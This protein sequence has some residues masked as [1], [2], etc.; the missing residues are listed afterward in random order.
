MYCLA[1]LALVLVALI[2]PLLCAAA[3]TPAY[4]H[5]HATLPAAVDLA[6]DWRRVAIRVNALEVDTMLFAY[7]GVKLPPGLT[8]MD[9]SW[10][11]VAAGQAGRSMLDHTRARH[12]LSFSV[13]R[14]VGLLDEMQAATTTTTT[15][16]GDD[17]DSPEAEE[18][19][20]NT[21][22]RIQRIHAGLLSFRG[23]PLL[24]HVEAVVAHQAAMH[25]WTAAR[26]LRDELGNSGYTVAAA[27]T[28][29]EVSTL[30]QLAKTGCYGLPSC[31]GGWGRVK[32]RVR[33]R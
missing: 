19:R 3:L 31:W 29:A 4:T 33:V 27:E 21:T 15:T 9:A 11:A 5:A 1:M 32:T 16:G 8:A 20:R 23:G 25:E 12:Q 14:T 18:H 26:W 10:A 17:D 13:D 7:Y 22:A 2:C 24:R 6:A 28:A 30:L